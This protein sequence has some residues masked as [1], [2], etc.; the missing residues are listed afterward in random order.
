MANVK[1]I[2]A[3]FCEHYP[4]KNE[5]SKTRLTKLIYLCDWEKAR[6][7]GEQMTSIKWYFDHY[8]P[9]VDDVMNTI[10]ENS[11]IFEV[12]NTLNF[13]GNTKSVIKLKDTYRTNPKSFDKDDLEIIDSVITSTKD[14]Y[15]N[16]FIEHVYNTKPIIKSD[17]F[18]ALDLVKTAKKK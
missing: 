5:L 18:Q 14:L 9:Y 11:A 12:E 17:R 1:N 4:H 6:T 3:Y 10:K 8:G 15:W 16:E 13:Y 2:A 7:H